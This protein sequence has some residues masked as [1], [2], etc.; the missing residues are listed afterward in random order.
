MDQTNFES[1]LV[2]MVPLKVVNDYQK[3]RIQD[4]FAKFK[5]DEIIEST[6]EIYVSLTQILLM[7]Q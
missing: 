2:Q 1:Q 5:F 3:D 6:P 4:M 7:L